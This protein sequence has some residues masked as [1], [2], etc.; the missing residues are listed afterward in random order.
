MAEYLMILSHYVIQFFEV[1]FHF[2]FQPGLLTDEVN[3]FLS[4]LSG[5]ALLLSCVSFSLC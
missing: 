5:A 3:P 1:G 4:F 2:P